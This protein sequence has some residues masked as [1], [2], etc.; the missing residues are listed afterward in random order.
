MAEAE[1]YLPHLLDKIE[2]LLERYG[3]QDVAP[4]LRLSGCPNSCSRSYLGEIGLIGR[5]VGR[6]DLRLGADSR[7]ER[8][9]ALYRENI[10]GSGAN[11][12]RRKAS[13]VVTM[14]RGAPCFF[15]IRL[16]SFSAA[17][18]LAVTTASKT[19]PSWSTARHR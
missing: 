3:L 16:R 12:R 1:R 4:L 6:Y 19:S 2:V 5:A 11:S 14:L 10:D 8:L 9:N 18:L 15:M 7:G 13:R 17:A